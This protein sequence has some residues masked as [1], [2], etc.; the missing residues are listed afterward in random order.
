MKISI[1]REIHAVQKFI[2]ASSLL[3][4]V[5]N[6]MDDIPFEKRISRGGVRTSAGTGWFGKEKWHW[7]YQCL[8]KLSRP[9]KNLIWLL[10]AIY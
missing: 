1:N 10:C 4:I 6:R 9:R 8:L 2:T 7:I 5:W 3:D